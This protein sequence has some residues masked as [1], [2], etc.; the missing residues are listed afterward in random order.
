[1]S[2]KSLTVS[3]PLRNVRSLTL[4]PGPS[5]KPKQHSGRRPLIPE[6]ASVLKE[7]GAV[8]ADKILEVKGPP[9]EDRLIL[10]T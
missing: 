10:P 6:H 1:M 2:E 4:N 9:D 5:R 7:V 3:H 8:A